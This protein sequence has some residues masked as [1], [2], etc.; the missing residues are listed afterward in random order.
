[1]KV[2]RYNPI[3]S[4]FEE[5]FQNFFRP[6]KMY[7]ELIRIFCKGVGSKQKLV[8]RA[9]IIVNSEKISITRTRS[10][11]FLRL[12]QCA[13]LLP[14]SLYPS[15]LHCQHIARI[16]YFALGAC[17]CSNAMLLWVK[18]GKKLHD[19]VSLSGGLCWY[20]CWQLN[21]PRNGATKIPA[22][23]VACQILPNIIAKLLVQHL[24]CS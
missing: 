8:T 1:M 24:H 2:C 21:W 23:W 3:K 16:L 18:E 20:S 14:L 9:T 19:P 7:I 10:L 6:Y 22:Y 13:L 5:S 15:P 4:K 12:L 17:F 11:L